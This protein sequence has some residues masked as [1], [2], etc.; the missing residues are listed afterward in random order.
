MCR[1]F[2]ERSRIVVLSI[3]TR[4]LLV[5]GFSLTKDCLTRIPALLR[6]EE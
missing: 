3:R 2:S 6:L 4:E 5:T 1:D